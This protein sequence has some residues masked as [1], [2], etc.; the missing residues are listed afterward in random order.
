M[1]ETKRETKALCA[2]TPRKKDSALT[3]RS[4]EWKHCFALQEYLQPKLVNMPDKKVLA[5]AT[6]RMRMLDLLDD[7]GN[8]I[9]VNLHWC[10]TIPPS[11][12]VSLPRP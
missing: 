9:W 5:A 2:K 3:I 7:Q 12:L 10:L 11:G 8:L 1:L 4:K 6:Q